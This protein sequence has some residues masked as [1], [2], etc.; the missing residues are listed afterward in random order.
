MRTNITAVA[1]IHGATLTRRQFVK[2]GGSLVVGLGVAKYGSALLAAAE[3]SA[4]K[5]SVD[6]TRVA[7]WFEIHADNTITLKTGKTDFGQSTV[8]TAYKQIVADE[9]YVPFEA[10]TTLIMGDTDRTPDGGVSAS[11]L[12][13][14]GPNMRKAAAY[15]REALLDL[16]SKKLGVDRAQLVVRDGVVSGGGKS[17]SYGQLVSGQELALNIPV[18]GDP[19]TLFGLSVTGNPPMKP[20]NQYTVIGKSYKNYVTESK[21]TAKETWATDVRLPG[22]LHGRVIHPKTLGSALMSAGEV[23]KTRFP[24]AQVIV[25]GN[26]VGVVA[27]TEWEAIRAAQQVASSTKWTEWKGLPGHA[28]VHAFFREKADWKS[29]PVVK[30]KDNKGNVPSAVAGAAKKLSAS[31]E[32]PFLKHAPIGPSVSLADV[33]ADG[34]VF[35]YTHNQHPAQLRQELALMLGTPIDNVVV[36]TFAGPGHYG[37]SNGGNSGSEDEAVILSKAVGRPVR[38]Q[39]MRPEDLQWSTSSPGGYSD[40]QIALDANGNMVGAQVD[41]YQPAGQDD[42]PIGAILAGLP[43]MDEPAVV[44]NALTGTIINYLSDQWVYDRVTNLAQAAYG[45]YQLGQKESP[46]KVGIRDHSLRTPTQLQQNFPREMA[47]NEAAALAN[48]DPLEY[49]L[50]HTTDKRLIAVLNAVRTASKWEP[51]PS[52]NP[53]ASSTGNVVTGRG[54]AVMQRTDAYWACTCQVSVNRLTGKVTVEKCA[55]ACEPGIV[56]NPLQIKRQIQ[57]GTMMAVSHALYEEA[58]FDESAITSRDWKTYPI[59]TMADMPEIEVIVVANPELGRYGGVSEAAN[60]V[61]LA[62]IAAAV[63]D[64]TGKVPRRLPLTPAYVAALV[65][66]KK[67]NGA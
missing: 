59:A 43:T 25:K 40:V 58:R 22:M 15:T 26:F 6:A 3:P 11:F 55:V 27:P 8:T 24:N 42:R 63:F 33:K 52:P 38:V 48:A 17:V 51:R 28:N 37:R 35:V 18:T 4:R 10:I 56:I 32:V 64:A 13:I 41:H 65:G 39:W 23:D 53:Q 44:Q 45:T 54:V 49:R 46:I 67:T 36:R 62:A 61:P 20:T 66:A 21:V 30:G 7:S 9:L 1:N 47:I 31:Y 34:T 57:G 16:A 60:T 5:N 2:A 14:G 50:R 19:A 12:H 29:A